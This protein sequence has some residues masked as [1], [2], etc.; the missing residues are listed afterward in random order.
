MADTVRDDNVDAHRRALHDRRT[1]APAAPAR[2]ARNDAD[3]EARDDDVSSDDDAD[4]PD[5][6]GASQKLLASVASMPVEVSAD[7][8]A[9]LS[10]AIKALIAALHAAESGAVRCAA[11]SLLRVCY[12][13][14]GERYLSVDRLTKGAR[15][16]AE[17]A[18]LFRSLGDA[19]AE[20]WAQL[21]LGQARFSLAARQQAETARASAKLEAAL[22][23]MRAALRDLDA[24]GAA[25]D[26]VGAAADADDGPRAGRSHSPP[27]PLEAS[28]LASPPLPRP[29]SPSRDVVVGCRVAAFEA[30]V[31]VAN[32]IVARACLVVASAKM[33]AAGA[34]AVSPRRRAGD[35]DAAVPSELLDAIAHASSADDDGALADAHAKAAAAHARA[36]GALLAEGGDARLALLL[37]R[38]GNALSHFRAAL[39]A[40]DLL[41]ACGETAKAALESLSLRV[42]AA[43]LLQRVAQH[44]DAAYAPPAAALGHGTSAPA[45]ADD[46]ARAAAARA[47]VAVLRTSL[48]LAVGASAALAVVAA[49]PGSAS[50]LLLPIVLAALVTMVR[51]LL[52]AL[53]RGGPQQG[54]Y[55]A[56]KETYAASLR[57]APTNAAATAA[58]LAH[59]AAQLRGLLQD[60]PWPTMDGE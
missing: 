26:A 52:R 21:R 27:P 15:H 47:A 40:S 45:R 48:D 14:L 1:N 18:E 28:P 9:N 44:L 35:D 55:A 41:H 6:R 50:S 38:A 11:E 31:K 20:S 8:E 17:G 46:G 49:A 13:A 22:E 53:V 33:A 39:Q 16:F 51:D 10:R 7:V 12:T 57:L 60:V 34:Y 58:F 54:A 3:T 19:R 56:L 23:T 36:A 43:A 29:V 30:S 42:D 25:L 32:S 4:G 59:A 2:R 37:R 5:A 24:V